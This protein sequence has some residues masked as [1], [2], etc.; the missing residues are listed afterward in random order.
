MVKKTLIDIALQSSIFV[1]DFS[2]HWDAYEFLVSAKDSI[3]AA[4]E[5][6]EFQ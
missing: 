6:D 5:H 3:A 1:T 2:Q 4:T